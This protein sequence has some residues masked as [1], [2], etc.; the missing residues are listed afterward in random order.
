[1]SPVVTGNTGTPDNPRR[2]GQVVFLT[3]SDPSL[4]EGFGPNHEIHWFVMQ[5]VP[6]GRIVGGIVPFGTTTAT[7]SFTVP[8]M[9]GPV[10]VPVEM[11]LRDVWTDERAVARADVYLGP[12]D[13]PPAPTP[14]PPTPEPPDA[15][16]IERT[17]QFADGP[18][19]FSAT[20]EVW[21]WLAGIG[22]VVPVHIIGFLWT[23]PYTRAAVEAKAAEY[24][25]DPTPDPDPTPEPDPDPTPEPDPDHGSYTRRLSIRVGA[26]DGRLFDSGVE[27]SSNETTN[28]T[29]RFFRQRPNAAEPGELVGERD[30]RIGANNPFTKMVRGDFG[31]RDADLCV[32]VSDSPVGSLSYHVFDRDLPVRYAAFPSLP[33]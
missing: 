29:L 30:F 2:S 33:G 23:S 18:A 17:V 25:P 8:L 26:Y 10:R 20:G 11:H 16:V 31:I 27:L 12:A 14:P 7:L 3:A 19:V 6:T 21:D 24:A 28:V 1:M 22:Y 32:V 4:P 15:E 13:P 9:S 5:P